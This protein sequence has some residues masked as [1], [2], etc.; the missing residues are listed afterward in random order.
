MKAVLAF[1]LCLPLLGA[2]AQEPTNDLAKAQQ[3][4][5]AQIQQE[6]AQNGYHWTPA[7]TPIAQ[8]PLEEFHAMLGLRLPENYEPPRAAPFPIRDDLPESFDWRDFD[9]VTP[10][11]NQ[12]GCGSCWDFAAVGALESVI[13]I[14]SGEELDLSEQQV[15][16]CAT[17]GYGCDG[18]WMTWAWEHFRVHGAV[19]EECMP[20]EADD[21]VPCTE[22]ECEKVAATKTWID[23]PNDIDAIKTAVYDYGP[24]TT[25]FHVYDDIAYYGGGCYE[26]EGDDPTNHAV[27]IVGW[28]DNACDGEGAWLIK[29]SWVTAG[30]RTAICGLS[31]A[32]A[33]L[34]QGQCSFTTTRRQT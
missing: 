19:T 3:E 34:A 10:V 32:P 13:K 17:P 29:N 33:T 18:G 15:L 4:R 28:D 25:T 23:I 14:Y 8:L 21:E 30:A 2:A 9:G 12:D 31:T 11:K 6:I 24:V 27:V 26:H 5:L 7:M 16:S 1:V 20:Y 22:D